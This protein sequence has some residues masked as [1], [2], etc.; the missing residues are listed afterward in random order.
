MVTG[1]MKL[2][3]ARKFAKRIATETRHGAEILKMIKNE[4]PEILI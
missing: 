4:Q 2:P 3:E 1:A